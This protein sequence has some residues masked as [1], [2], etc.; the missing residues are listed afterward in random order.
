MKR[1]VILIETSR[2]FGRQLLRGIARYAK[3]K[4]S[5]SFYLEPRGLK[6]DVPKLAKWKAHGIIMR[7]SIIS[8]ELVNMKLPTII[9]LHDP[10]RY[11]G[12]P[13]VIT[14]NRSIAKLAAEHLLNRGL[15]NYAFCGLDEFIWSNER[16]QEFV[17]I[18]KEAG[19]KTYIY[20]KPATK[21]FGTWEKEQMFMKS[22]LKKLPK[23]IGIFACNDDRGQHV[24]EACK[25]ANLKVPDDVAVIGVD[26]D[27][28]ICSFCDPPLT[29]VALNLEYAG[30]ASA[31]LLDMLMNGEKMNSQEIRVSATHVVRR[32]STDCLF[33]E[34]SNVANAIHFIRQNSKIKICVSD[35]VK[36]T[37][38]SRRA[39]ESRFQKK[40]H[41]SILQEI[42]RARIEQM[43]QLLIETDLSIS[44]IISLF[45]FTDVEHVSR[46]FRK[47]KGMGLREFR[48]LHRGC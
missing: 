29:S 25:A 43:S 34:D 3:L 16:K 33:V 38:L 41:R 47:E 48:K 37:S 14:E 4:N 46:Y 18:L 8:K 2:E 39:L 13:A 5:W 26:N 36:Q 7:N 12:L 42:R 45:N 21:E 44:E 24:L 10:N 6:S 27:E 15:K 23:P 32:Q 19:F 31:E 11:R 30:F 1:V 9:V 35:V 40:L 20:D 22:W 28:I 17:D